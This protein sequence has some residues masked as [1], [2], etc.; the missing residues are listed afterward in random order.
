MIRRSLRGFSLAILMLLAGC[1]VFNNDEPRIDRSGGP[2]ADKHYQWTVGPGI[3]LLT[4]PAVPV[5]AFLESRL[6]AQT[7]SSLDYAYPGFDRAVAAAPAN[8][9][10]FLTNNL[11]PDEHL[12][13]LDEIV[14]GNSRF[15]I[16][17]ITRSGQ[18]VTAILCSYR[19]GLAQ[20]RENGTFVSVLNKF[21]HNDGIDALLLTLAAPADESDSELP[22]QTG[23]APAP[24][25]DVFGDWKVTGFLN[26][27]FGPVPGYETVWP[28][29]EAD[30]AKCVEQAPDPP[31]RRAFLKEGGHPRSDFPT[32]PPSPG[33]P[34]AN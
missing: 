33:W 18:T 2:L 15:H 22:P 29:F 21:V 20:E 14:V 12:G 34:D 31:E 16:Q 27:Y 4:G 30:T 32:S 3:D 1:Q 28:T 26:G 9:K 8:G 11:R 19:Y 6:D 13:P 24:V 5:R 25:V 7:M 23:P 10:D 17:S